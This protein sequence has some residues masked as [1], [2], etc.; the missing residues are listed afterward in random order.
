MVHKKK[1]WLLSIDWDTWI[2]E[3]PR[4]EFGHAETYMFATFAWLTRGYA[5]DEMTTTGEE[6]TFWQRLQKRTKYLST[7]PTLLVSD[8]HAMM[9]SVLNTYDADEVVLIDA[10][11]DMW[12][13]DCEGSYTC[14]DWL[15]VWLEED[16]RNRA[17]WIQPKWSKGYVEIPTDLKK[18]VRHTWL[19][20]M[21]KLLP[22]TPPSVIHVCRSGCWTPPWLDAA[23]IDFVSGAGLHTITLQQDGWLDPM[24][25]RWSETERQGARFMYEQQTEA[26]K[27]LEELKETEAF[28]KLKE[29]EEE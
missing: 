4:W 25:E 12:P 9:G 10:H 5:I 13:V 11:H 29:T 7:Y 16:K 3:D 28:K 27:K 14:S 1:P 6:Q 8:S 19:P 20:T 2:P 23:F 18:Q 26:F 21:E 15:R 24:V 17:H 22:T